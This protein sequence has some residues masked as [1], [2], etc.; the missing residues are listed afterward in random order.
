[1]KRKH[2]QTERWSLERI[3]CGGQRESAG[4]VETGELRG[5]GVEC[6]GG[7]KALVLVK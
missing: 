6:E 4:L 1:L 3:D 7:E 5:L 2:L